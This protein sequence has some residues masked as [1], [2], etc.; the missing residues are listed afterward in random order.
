MTR[1]LSKVKVIVLCGGKGVRL[2]PLTYDCP[3]PLV[4]VRGRPIIDYIVEHLH[5]HGLFNITLAGGYK[6]ELLASHFNGTT[7]EVVDTGDIDISQRIA[8]LDD[9]SDSDTLVLYGDTLSD[10]DI[11][12]LLNTHQSAGAVATVTVWP[13]QSS[14]GLFSLDE[15]AKVVQYE[16]KPRLDKWINIGYFV[17]SREAL[18]TISSAASFQS[19]LETLVAKRHLNAYRHHGFHVTVNTTAELEEAEAALADWSS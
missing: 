3:K 17:L 8:L 5:R 2:R 16:E 9:G 7:V 10:V 6:V 13:L 14:F 11:S 19:A 18:N 4:A 1:D 15:N 12:D